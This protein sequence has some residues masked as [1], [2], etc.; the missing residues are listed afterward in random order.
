MQFE[1]TILG[2]TM[3]TLNKKQSSNQKSHVA[4]AASD[5]LIEGKKLANELYRDGLNKVDE[6]EDNL[7]KHSD[8]LLKK[9]QENPLTSI[10][11]AG[12]IGFL[13]SKILKR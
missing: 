10:L 12:G 5:L 3:D 8:E 1:L 11:I 2:I 6:A 9:V 4:D 7:K 13:L